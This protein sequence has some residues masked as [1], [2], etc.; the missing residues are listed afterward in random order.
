MTLTRRDAIK[1]IGGGAALLGLGA[2]GRTLAADG[3][4]ADPLKQPFSLPN[5]TYTFDSMEPNF[6]RETMEIHYTKHHAAYVKN[7]NA[8]LAGHPELADKGA[9]D[10]IRNLDSVPEPLRTTL[11]DNVG[12]HLN[13]TFWWR[14]LSA[15][16]GGEP[17]GELADAIYRTFQSFD[18]FKKRFKDTAMKRFGSGWEWLTV[19]KTGPLRI[20]STANQ[21]S[22]LAEQQIPLIGLDVWEHAY[23][24]RYQNV[25]ADYIDAFWEVVDWEQAGRNYQAARA[26]YDLA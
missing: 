1:V 12:G 9:E 4:A 10:I 2:V 7:A 22:V 21:D 8:A 24:L 17:S 14:S 3:G 11:R 20:H 13:H 18:E 19:M 6:D 15:R 25:R 26:A 16:G 23:Y 5:L